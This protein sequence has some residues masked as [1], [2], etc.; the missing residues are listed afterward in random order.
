MKNKQGFVILFTILISV[1]IF[2]MGLGIYSIALRQTVLSGTSR[3]A[4]QAFYAADAGMECALFAERYQAFPTGGVIECDGEGIA[5]P[6]D[7][8]VVFNVTV[9]GPNAS[10]ATVNVF[11]EN[12]GRRIISQGFNVCKNREP[13]RNNPRLVERD[14]DAFY[15]L[16]Q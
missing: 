9:G 12:E 7:D 14:L 5:I 10:C 15:P 6:T 3:E 16:G 2:M 1:I 11:T 4:Q 13:D 8:P